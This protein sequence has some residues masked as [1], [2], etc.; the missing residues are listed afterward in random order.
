[1]KLAPKTK[2]TDPR[3]EPL[4]LAINDQG[5]ATWVQTAPT[6]EEAWRRLALPGARDDVDPLAV[7]A[8]AEAATTLCAIGDAIGLGLRHFGEL[9]PD[10]DPPASW[11]DRMVE[12][13]VQELEGWW[14]LDDLAYAGLKEGGWTATHAVVLADPAWRVAVRA[15]WQ[16][17][18]L[19]PKQPSLALD[20]LDRYL[21]EA[22]EV[23]GSDLEVVK[24]AGRALVSGAALHRFSHWRT[25]R[26]AT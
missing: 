3:T 2:Q 23:Y 11:V 9:A 18:P 25:T 8:L 5:L 14:T 16:A 1:M 7:A 19:K 20:K 17:Q 21:G 10:E 4:P 13:H 24:V 15:R 22:V 26:R 6:A 12:L